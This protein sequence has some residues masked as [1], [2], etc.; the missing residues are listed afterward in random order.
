MTIYF[1]INETDDLEY[2]FDLEYVYFSKKELIRDLKKI[3]D[4]CYSIYSADSTVSFN[5]NN[6]LTKHTFSEFEEHLEDS[7][8]K[9]KLYW[10]RL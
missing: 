10:E 8:A 7:D 1:I 2:H 6:K 4:C 5:N 9:Y 3:K